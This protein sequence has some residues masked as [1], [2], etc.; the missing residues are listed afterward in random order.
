[1][2]RNLWQPFLLVTL[3]LAL[4]PGRA[5]ADAADDQY[6]V[7][8]GH[9]AGERWELAVAEF[10][11]FGDNFPADGRRQ[12][13]TFYQAEALVQLGQYARARTA[14]QGILS[15]DASGSFARRALFRSGESAYMS[16]QTAEAKIDLERFA[17]QYPN[18]DLVAIALAY[19]GDIGL[20]QG[21]AAGAEATFARALAQFSDGPRAGEYRLG[22]GRAL[23]EQNRY[24]E[25]AVHFAALAGNAELGVEAQYWLGLV[26]RAAQRWDAAAKT[27]LAAADAA[28]PK[29]RL[30]DAIR[31]HAGDS[32][33]RSGDAPRATEQFDLVLKGSPEGRWADD[34]LAGNLRAASSSNDHA[35]VD[36]LATE[37]A[38]RFNDSPLNPEVGFLHGSSLMASEKFAEAIAPLE[39]A[40]KGPIDSA[41]L[42]SC[43]A[44][45]AICLARL[46]RLDEA[47]ATYAAFLRE[48]ADHELVLPTTKH[49]AEAA[50]AAGDQEWSSGL[51]SKIAD[52]GEAT[53]T[54]AGGLS[55]LAWSQLKSEDLDRSA[56]TFEQILNDHPGDPRAAEA[57]LVRGQILERQGKH[58]PALVMYHLVIDKHGDSPH[59]AAALMAA[60]RLHDRLQQ[61]KSA[62][63]FYEQLIEQHPDFAQLDSAIYGQAW[64][65]VELK[66]RDEADRQFE[67]LHGEFPTSEHWADATYLLAESAAGADRHERAEELL[68]TLLIMKK[69]Q[70]VV[71]PRIAARALYLQG[72][73]AVERKKWTDVAAPMGQLVTD[74]PDSSMCLAANFWIAEA[75]FRLGEMTEAAELLVA[76]AEQAR[77]HDEPWLGMISLR[78]AQVL[79]HQ[80]KWGEALKIA[81]GIEAEHPTFDQLYE[82][83]YVIGRSLAARGQLDDARAAYLRVVQS[84]QGGKT[85]TA[86]MAQWMIGETFMHQKDYEQARREYLRGEILYA[87]PE[88][89]AR[90]LLEAGKCHELAGQWQQAVELYVQLAKKY[91]DTDSTDEADRRVRVARQRAVSVR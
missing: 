44:Q 56:A 39:V 64:V 17:D 53:K 86:A 11:A 12:A 61:N 37:F 16:S 60:A 58:D 67:R 47:K 6:A 81:Q 32:L 30:L 87:Y 76:V 24:D 3:A 80:N 50:Y 23:L 45:L 49:L 46:G 69:D 29:D 27:L 41:A 73:M 7:A 89:Q 68:S 20:K 21:D 2:L 31:F 82:V 74:Y 42:P 43:R 55:G 8:A 63:G 26:H 51:F 52:E 10:T 79:A 5:L 71:A 34:C 19:L 18:D 75:A 36:R 91:P 66:R 62:L 22:L 1:M 9:Y 35:A 88:W 78:R 25:A 4:L 72:H 14:F 77:G 48:H 54:V 85:E 40:L 57:A 70:P 15:G 59:L 33:L 84:A 65:L 90:S 38:E 28:S 83:D 13:A